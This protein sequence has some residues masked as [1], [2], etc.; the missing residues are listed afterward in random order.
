MGRTAPTTSIKLR[1]ISANIRGAQEENPR[2]EVALL[3][4]RGGLILRTW[5]AAHT[6][7]SILQ[8]SGNGRNGQATENGRVTDE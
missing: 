2:V 5:T 3:G 7:G 8:R 6:Q 4:K 1:I